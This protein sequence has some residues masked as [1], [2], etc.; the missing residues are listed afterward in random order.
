MSFLD[1]LYAEVPA[2]DHARF[3]DRGHGV[4][5]ALPPG[6]DAKMIHSGID[7]GMRQPLR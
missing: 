1:D 7:A 5:P 6:F 4:K 3:V 2:A